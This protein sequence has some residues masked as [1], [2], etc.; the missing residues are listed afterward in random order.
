MSKDK[1]NSVDT[2]DK[3][4]TKDSLIKE[5]RELEKERAQLNSIKEELEKQG[6]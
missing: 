5:R 6:R 4:T 2:N 1:D 3:Q